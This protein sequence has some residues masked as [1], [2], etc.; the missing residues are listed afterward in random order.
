VQAFQHVAALRPDYA[1]ARTNCAIVEILWQR[2]ADA[3]THLEQA[4][5][6]A[7]GDARALYYRALVERNEGHVDAAIADLEQV[8]AKFPQSR[9]AHRELGYSFYQLHDYPKARAQY[10][11]VQ[12][13]DPDDLSAHYNL[14]IL[15]RRLGLKDKAALEAATFTDQKDDPTASTYALAWLRG[16]PEIAN[17][18]VAWH[19]HN[20]DSTTDHPE[21]PLPTAFS[22]TQQ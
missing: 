7:P 4:L 12:A 8:A 21:G 13:I 17:E 16:H 11:A 14:A 5:K 1:D 22:A 19:A 20:L 2:Y 10:E 3:Q 6:L 9:D 15:Y 18:S